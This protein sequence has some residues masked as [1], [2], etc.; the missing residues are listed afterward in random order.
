VP[1]Q[2][3]QQIP[4]GNDRKKSKG[5]GKGDSRFPGGNDRKKRKGNGSRTVVVPTLV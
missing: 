3:A 5:N 2:K 1:F 4:C